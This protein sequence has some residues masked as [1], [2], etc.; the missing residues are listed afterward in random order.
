MS[1]Y[2]TLGVARTATPEDIKKAYRAM[3]FKYHPD[4]NRDD[5]QA[6]TKFKDCNEAYEVLIDFQK[7]HIYDSRLPRPKPGKLKGRKGQK[8][9]FRNE[10]ERLDW[11][12]ANDPNLGVQVYDAPPPKFDIWGN[13]L[14][15]TQPRP[16]HGPNKGRSPAP[17]RSNKFPKTGF[18]DIFSGQYMSGEQPN[19]R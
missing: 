5:P 8:P 2:D 12:R 11:I 14:S 4:Q 17:L 3:A 1:Y 6:E 18:I 16:H 13:P 9:S 7:R 10:D 15:E 19:I